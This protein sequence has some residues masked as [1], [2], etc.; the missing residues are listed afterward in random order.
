MSTVAKQNYRG[1]YHYSPKEKWMNDPN[2]LVYF[3]GEY[4]LFY[5]HH[6]GGMTWGPM[7]WGHAAS[8]D[9]V[10][11]EEFGIALAPDENGTIFSGSAVVDWRNTTGFFG[12]EPGLVA[13]YTRHCEAEGTP[14]VQT[15]CLAFSADKGRTW[16]KYEGNPVLAH[17]V[18]ADFRDPKVFWHVET[19]RWVMILACGQTVCL[20]HSPDLKAWTFGSEFGDGLGFH[21][22][23]WECPDLFPLAVDGDPARTRWV[24]LVSV[25]DD[26]AFPEGSRMQYFTG[27]FDGISFV[28]DA[29]S[30]EVR[31]LD[32]GR[33]H[34]A[35][36]SWSDIPPE[37]GR[38]L[39][40]GWMSNWKYANLTP[41]DMFRGA[42]TVPRELALED[43]D[44]VVILAQR[45]VRE[46]E[47]ARVPVLT[48][49][50]AT[51][52]EA[53]AALQAL[54]LD[55]YELVAEAEAGRSFAFKVRMGGDQET[56]VGVDAD[57]EEVYVDRTRSGKHEFHEQFRGVHTAAL[58]PR[59]GRIDLRI[60]VDRASVEVFACEGQAVVTDLIFP[61]PE[62]TGLSLEADDEDFRL[63][64]LSV[65]EMAPRLPE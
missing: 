53:E 15:Q 18:Y 26:P 58:R 19:R 48:L 11:W 32:G 54:R 38:R 7:H 4:H 39:T 63:I 22:G 2:G 36:V 23:V 24:M 57:R 29:D 61:D 43:R 64:S 42:M 40:I 12:E 37:D 62:S 13:I 10:H 51:R 1:R 41:A 34:Y 3:A 31:W 17:D 21:G 30:K 14:P 56:V 52:R 6:P 45:P 35:G 16:T 5:Q 8:K 46:L 9:L 27:D 49:A 55:S 50:G 20:Y 44:G 65:F 25:G 28:P 47:R 60:F 33:D 59:G